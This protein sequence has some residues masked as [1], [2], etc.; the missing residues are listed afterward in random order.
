MESKDNSTRNINEKI[1]SFIKSNPDGVSQEK[2]TSAIPINEQSIAD[3]LNYLL[4]LN[5]ISYIET[6][7]GILF[8]YRSEKEALKLRDL[9][10][11]ENAIYELVMQSGGNGIS[12]MDIKNNLKI[13]NTTYVNK[14]LN[15]L[16]KKLLIKSLKVLNTK[17]KKVWMGID[18]EPSQDVIGGIWCNGQEFDDQLVNVF[19]E[20][21]SQYIGTQ[22]QVSRSELLFFAKS[23]NLIKNQEI[24][25]DDIQKIINI[26]VF[27]GKIEPIFPLNIDDKFL[28]NKYALLIDKG[29]PQQELI[30]Y[31][32]IKESK[33]NNIFEYLP[34]FVCT[35][36]K[37]CKNDNVVNPVECPFNKALFKHIEEFN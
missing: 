5:R 23:T 2:L 30:R 31:R 19:C 21:C 17:N 33:T 15:K 13:N 7:E 9:S 35:S 25:E 27:D 12:T 8:K 14:I 6:S 24:K 1:L 11:D 16:S 34:C 22:K 37:E 20:K 10:K 29:H 36:F 26:L 4:G 32:K 28:G 3:A 18:V